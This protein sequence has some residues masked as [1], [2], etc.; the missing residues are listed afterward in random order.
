MKT[1]TYP[2]AVRSGVNSSARAGPARRTCARH[3]AEAARRSAAATSSGRV[4]STAN[5]AAPPVS[6]DEINSLV[7]E[8]DLVLV[9]GDLGQSDDPADL[10]LELQA[11]REELDRLTVP[12]YLALG[13]HDVTLTGDSS[14]FRQNFGETTFRF[15]HK[16]MQFISFRTAITRTTSVISTA[17]LDSLRAYLSEIQ[18]SDPLIV[19]AHHPLGPLTPFGVTNRQEF[20]NQIDGY[21]V[22]AVFCG[23]Y[24]GVFEEQRNGVWYCTSRALSLQRCNHDGGH[25]KG[26]RVVS[27]WPDYSISSRFFALGH[28]PTFEPSVPGLHGTGN[29]YAVPGRELRLRVSAST[30]DGDAITYAAANLPSGAGFDPA[31]RLF[32]WTP[33]AAQVGLH[34][35]IEFLAFDETGTDTLRLAVRVLDEACL[36]EDFDP[37]QESWSAMGGFWSVQNGEALQSLATGGS[38]YYMAGDAWGDFFLEAD[39]LHEMGIGYAGLVFRY[40]DVNNNYYVWNNSSQ[41][42][43]RR[44]INGVASQ[45]GPSIPVGPITGWHHV[46]VEAVGTNIKIYWDGELRVDVEDP[47]F[48]G[49]KAGLV[50]SQA[51]ARFDNVVVSGCPGFENRAPELQRIG[52]R[53][54]AMGQMLLIGVEASDPEGDPLTYSVTGLPPNARWIPGERTFV[55]T[56]SPADLGNWYGTTFRVTDGELDD[57]ES[58]DFTVIDRTTSCL[59]DDFDDPASSSKWSPSGGS[60][61]IVDGLYV[62]TAYASAI[63]TLSNETYDD[64]TLEARLRVTGTGYG[65]L[66][67]RV[68]DPT[69][70]YYLFTSNNSNEAQ[71]RKMEGSS[72]R[73]LASGGDVC[74]GVRGNWHVYRVQVQ[75]DVIR[76]WIDGERRFEIPDEGLAGPPAYLA[77]GIGL[78]LKD[79]T[80]EVDYVNVFHCD[81]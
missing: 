60:W 31:T 73:T 57:A 42:A 28:P 59:F 44:R 27:V 47:T 19:F 35:G 11:A 71:I 40:L 46:R 29:R 56:P 80:L 54:V 20:Y 23:H 78:R 81:G 79:A 18:P 5:P 34:P 17:A 25:E 12:Y 48:M 50:C 24:H 64:F 61:G 13:N 10:A 2:R 30:L 58:V 45:V 67:F 53:T 76:V 6:A 69:H 51:T 39:V 70:Y 37:V 41:I 14:A 21:D 36:Y 1:S 68:Q 3:P 33:E 65:N 66:V 7:P 49:G 38:Y 26:Y 75:D 22:K 43:L 63:S 16:G 15:S 8:I 52:H 55:W 32:S 62:G 72:Y 77:G 4:G 74:G 9:A